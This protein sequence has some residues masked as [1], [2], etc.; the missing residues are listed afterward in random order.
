MISSEAIG[1]TRRSRAVET[2]VLGGLVAG[3]LDGSDAALVITRISGVSATRVFQFI[4]SGLLGLRAFQEGSVAALISCGIH[5]L[6]ALTVAITYYLLSLKLSGLLKKPALFGPI[7]GFG[8]F[9]FM[10]DLIVPLSAA[11]KQP[12]ASLISL[13]NLVISHT[14]FVGLPIALIASRMARA[15]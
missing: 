12:P 13:L 10:H 8:V 11:P 14:I 2:I 1:P 5:F 4:A 3:V 15:G 9:C 7:F 6:I